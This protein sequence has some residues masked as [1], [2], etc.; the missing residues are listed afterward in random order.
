MTRHPLEEKYGLTAHELL[1]AL[2]KRFRA[3]VTLEGAVAEV[4]ME[5]KIKELVGSL[6]ARYEVHDIDGQPDFS[7]WLSS[8]LKPILVECK[9]V[10]DTEE[11]YRKGGQVVAYKVETQKTRAATGDR[12]SRYY[13]INQFDL[14]GVCI[15]KKTGRW[16]DFVFVRV[17]DLERHSSHPQK[18]AVM[19]R[20][21]LPGIADP[22]PWSFALADVLRR[23]A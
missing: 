21:P 8:T 2:D 9:N 18:L 12:T 3:K 17:A 7:I 6:V 23:F 13:G 10:R 5:K 22:S 19:Q 15:G 4:H 1:E 16:S 11:A 14:L 20:V